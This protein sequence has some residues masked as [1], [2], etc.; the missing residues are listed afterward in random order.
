MPRTSIVK[1]I[2]VVLRFCASGRGRIRCIGP[3]RSWELIWPSDHVKKWQHDAFF[4]PPKAL[5]Y[6]GP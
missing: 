4:P 1:S 5:L 3:G 6:E 2:S